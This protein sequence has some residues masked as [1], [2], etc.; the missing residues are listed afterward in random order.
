VKKILVIEDDQMVRLTT[1]DLLE[2]EGFETLVA[3]NGRS[4]VKLAQ[5]HLPDLI[6]CD[7]M[8]PELDGYEVLNIL[9]QSQTTSSIPFIFLTANADKN[10]IQRG[11]ELGAADYLTKPFA[12]KQLL[13][14]I[15]THLK[16]P[17]SHTTQ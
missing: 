1:L 10:A 5:E 9:H 7:I 8:I 17:T 13:N 11:L 15:H 6:I 12:L 14:A 2:A 4:G 3:D 16:K